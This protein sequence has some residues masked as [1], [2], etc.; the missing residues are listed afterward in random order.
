[1]K[2]EDEIWE[3]ILG[4][5]SLGKVSQLKKIEDIEA[6]KED[7]IGTILLVEEITKQGFGVSLPEEFFLD[8]SAR[9]LRKYLQ[10]LK[11]RRV[12]TKKQ[13][14]EERATPYVLFSEARNKMDLNVFYGG[15]GWRGISD[16]RNKNFFL[17]S[18]LEGW[19]LFEIG[20]SLIRSQRYDK[21]E[22][23]EQLSSEERECMSREISKLTKRRINLKQEIMR[24]G[25]T[26][27]GEVPSRTT[28]GKI[29]CDLRADGFPVNFKKSGS[30]L[31]Y[32]SWF[33]L[34]CHYH[35]CED[36]RMFISYARP[37]E[38]SFCAHDIAFIIKNHVDDMKY[39]TD[40]YL[41]FTPFPKPNKELSDSNR[42]YRK[43]VFKRVDGQRSPISKTDREG[44]LFCM[45]KATKAKFF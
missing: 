11:W 6:E 43:Q 20:R 12:K 13:A 36:K 19:E 21:P 40:P 25:G 37:R 24:R 1:M 18:W 35:S 17:Y 8:L 10:P 29:Y 41:V 15:T 14:I 27:T 38:E 32:S 23:L 45:L 31:F 9:V 2:N 5:F 7:F 4:N 33:D 30:D 42:R 22:D 3:N 16:S 28:R 39:H 26:R 34:T 44:L